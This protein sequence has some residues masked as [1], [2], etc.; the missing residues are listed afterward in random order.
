MEEIWK[1][2]I[3]F[4][5][6]YEIS[7]YGR[8]KSY[9]SGN[10]GRVLSTKNS[11]GDYLRIV[12]FRDKKTRKSISI[13]RLVAEHFIP[14][15]Y[16]LPQVNHIDGNRQNNKYDN[17]EWCTGKHNI[18]HALQL[19]PNMLDG[20]IEYNKSI[21]PK[22][23]LQIAKNGDVVERFPSAKAA[24]RKTGIC[25]RNIVQVANHDKNEHGYLRKTAGGYL[26]RFESEVMSDD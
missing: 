13:H 22:P 14:N 8:I 25:S 5:G 18:H 21:R 2:I 9:R 12:L 4:E 10:G 6:C 26:W 19:H 3:G 7:N 20:M 1:P 17:L 11:K 15:P 16:N 23:I 24:S